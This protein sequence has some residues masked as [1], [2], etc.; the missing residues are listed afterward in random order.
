M[1]RSATPDGDDVVLS[2]QGWTERLAAAPRPGLAAWRR[3]RSRCRETHNE[4]VADE[5][6]RLISLSP[7]LAEYL[8]VDVAEAA[9]QPMTRALRLE[10]NEL[11]RCR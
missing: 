3:G 4:W 8:G 10:E 6:L 11:A 1:G 2:L 5:E 9:G 7:E